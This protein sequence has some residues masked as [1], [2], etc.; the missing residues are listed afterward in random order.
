M[1]SLP[2]EL[3]QRILAEA[4]INEDGARTLGRF[5]MV[6][7]AFFA[8]A[9][10][11]GLW[12]TFY[13]DRYKHFDSAQD[14]DRRKRLEDDWSSMYYERRLQD[15][16]ALQEL[17][18]LIETASSRTRLILARGIVDRGLE[19]YDALDATADGQ[20]VGL[21]EVA[22]EDHLLKCGLLEG[23]MKRRTWAYRL[24]CIITTR[25]ALT[26]WTRLKRLDSEEEDMQV[27][28]EV[29]FACLSSFHGFLGDDVRFLHIVRCVQV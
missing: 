13:N 12:K 28:F 20:T 23:E 15:L 17:D 1:S 5:S 3:L 8:L 2:P 6:C 21:I 4:P 16:R 10:D 22:N 19:I 18:E 9:R 24:L 25:D 27:P 14:A 26:K 11:P 7:K 29:A